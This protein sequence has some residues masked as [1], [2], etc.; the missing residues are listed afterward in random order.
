MVSCMHKL[1]S[2]C[3]DQMLQKIF[4]DTGEV[5]KKCCRNLVLDVGK[6]C[7]DSMTSYV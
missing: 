1:R 7:H 4:Y 6:D 5:N 3:G 2:N